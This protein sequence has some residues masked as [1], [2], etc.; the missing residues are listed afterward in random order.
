MFNS[1]KEFILAVSNLIT[2]LA[3]LKLEDPRAEEE[4]YNL[5]RTALKV[6][7]GNASGFDLW[8]I[9]NNLLTMNLPVEVKN[10]MSNFKTIFHGHF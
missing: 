8:R 10:K 3:G 2:Y 5:L 7:K 4:R 1:D 6:R 9:L